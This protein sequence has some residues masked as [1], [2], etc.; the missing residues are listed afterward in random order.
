[1]DETGPA[2]VPNTQPQMPVAGVQNPVAV[3]TPVTEQQPAVSNPVVSGGVQ[4]PQPEVV[5]SA[6]EAAKEL[7]G[8]KGS[9]MGVWV[10]ILLLLLIVG[11]IGYWILRMNGLEMLS[12][13]LPFSFG[14]TT[15][16]VETVSP[17]PVV[18]DE[19]TTQLMQQGSS[20]EAGAI[21][22]DLNASDYS[23]LTGELDKI[24]QE[25][26]Q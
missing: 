17:V 24:D 8:E 10:G 2:P 23:G 14:T 21:E 19:G 11:G 16:G 6:E 12:G 22:Q 18:E 1:M 7:V 4:N 20:D 5:Q 13:V 25:L 9:N 3:G 26:A 15:Q